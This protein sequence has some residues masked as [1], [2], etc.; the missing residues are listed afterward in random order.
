MVSREA[1]FLCSSSSAAITAAEIEQAM[2]KGEMRQQ[3]ELG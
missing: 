3:F 2:G 1:G